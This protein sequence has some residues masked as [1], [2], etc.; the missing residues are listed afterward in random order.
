MNLQGKTVAVTGASGMIGVYICRSLLRA[1]VNV[2]GVVRN[3]AKAAFLADEGVI[4]RQADLADTAALT[5]AFAGCDAVVANAA[6]YVA[7]KSMSAWAEHEKA[8]LDGT[9]NVFDAAHQAGVRRL[10][11]IS[12]F[13]IYKW[14]VLRTLDENSPQLDGARR[15]GGPYRASK[16][17]SER[18]AWDMAASLD[19]ELTTLRPTA[20]YGARDDNT[21]RQIYKLLR[22]PVLPLP[23][24]SF[25][26]VYAGDVA[27]AVT[28]ALRND[29][30][31]GQTY[32]VGGAGHQV[33]D[34][35]KAVVT[36]AGHGPAVLGLPM[37][38]RI[39][40]DNSKA[41]REIGFRNRPPAEAL[42][43]I[44]A[45]DPPQHR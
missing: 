5:R 6:M 40:I 33:S 26:F 43:E 36:A 4:F 23:S 7:L 38:V 2:I 21:M 10:V 16:Q 27:D 20:V 13:G 22:L 9:R 44:I 11:Q 8:N 1:G 45:E 14:S 32:N 42:A 29:A 3:P 15:Q 39:R 19:L 41:E 35:L 24:I 34:F 25:P 37:P 18:M 31:I 30:S 17:I 12:T 28:G